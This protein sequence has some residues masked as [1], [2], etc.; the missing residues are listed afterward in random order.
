MSILIAIL[1]FATVIPGIIYLTVALIKFM[2]SKD[3]FKS[4][5]PWLW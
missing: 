1:F 4:P 3:M 5:F 2:F